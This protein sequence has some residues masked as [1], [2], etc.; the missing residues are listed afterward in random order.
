[1]KP[2]P[3][4]HQQTVLQ[5]RIEIEQGYLPPLV[6]LPERFGSYD[7][8]FLCYPIWW[9]TIPPAVAA[10]ASGLDW[11]GKRV[12]PFAMSHASGSANSVFDIRRLCSG[13]EV[14]KGGEVEPTRRNSRRKVLRFTPRL[15]MLPSRSR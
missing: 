3:T 14:A 1:M 12:I 13:A 9:F 10:F 11:T 5:S 7:T 6:M 2:Y 4:S 15:L 8:V